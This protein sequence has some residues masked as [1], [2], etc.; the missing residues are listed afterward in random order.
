SKEDPLYDDRL[1]RMLRAVCA[2]R[3]QDIRELVIQERSIEAAHL[4]ATR[5]TPA[6]L[7]ANYR[8]DETLATPVPQNL[9]IIDDVVTTGCHYRADKQILE[10]RFAGTP[11]IGLFLA[12]RV[13][14]SVDLDFDILE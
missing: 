6:D 10:N 8:L 11:I 1:V 9:W 2:G 3:R 7:I 5:P 12:R 4:S 14:K 13:P